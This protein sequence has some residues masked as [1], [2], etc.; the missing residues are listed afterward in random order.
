MVKEAVFTA[1]DADP[2]KQGMCMSMRFALPRY[3]V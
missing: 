3:I 1:P 2:D